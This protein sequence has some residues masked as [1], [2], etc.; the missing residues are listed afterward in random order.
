MLSYAEAL[1]ALGLEAPSLIEPRQGGAALPEGLWDARRAQI[2][3]DARVEHPEAPLWRHG[4][5]RRQHGVHRLD[6]APEGAKPRG[7]ELKRRSKWL[8]RPFTAINSEG[9]EA[10]DPISCLNSY[11]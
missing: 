4:P 5:R 8:Q 3:L 11:S 1:S 9:F 10:V 6:A 7:R 2:V